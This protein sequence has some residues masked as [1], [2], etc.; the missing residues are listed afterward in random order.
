MYS[1]KTLFIRTLCDIFYNYLDRPEGSKYLKAKEWRIP[2]VNVSW[3]S[4][5]VVGHLDALQLPIHTRYLQHSQGKDFILDLSRVP[6]LMGE[7]LS[8]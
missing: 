6:H 2:V 4:D 5:L 8:F 3:L 1:L 7:S